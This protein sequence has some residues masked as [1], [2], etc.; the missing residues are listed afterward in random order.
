MYGHAKQVTQHTQYQPARIVVRLVGQNWFADFV[1]DDVVFDL[2][3]TTMIPTPF[4]LPMSAQQV[5]REVQARNP[6][7]IV[8]LEG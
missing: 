3:G 4:C 6:L 2:F 7:S 8:T 5:L 1:D